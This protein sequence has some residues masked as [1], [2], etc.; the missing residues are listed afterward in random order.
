MVFITIV[1]G[2]FVNQ[3]SYPTAGLT[4]QQRLRQQSYQLTHQ[5]LTDANNQRLRAALGLEDE[6]LARVAAVLCDPGQLAASESLVTA[7]FLGRDNW[8]EV[9]GNGENRCW[10]WIAIHIRPYTL[11]L[12]VF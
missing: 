7:V 6:R 11:S 4:L 3:L 9:A 8:E 12:C 10:D 5:A 1:T 2:A